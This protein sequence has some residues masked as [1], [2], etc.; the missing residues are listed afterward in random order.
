MKIK[1]LLS[2]LF[3]LFCAAV[4]HAQWDV[5]RE[6]ERMMSF[7]SRP[8]FR[9]EFANTDA[10][11][12]ESV[13]KDFAKKNFSAKLKKSKGEWTATKLRSAFM[14]DEPYAIYSTIE[15][16]GDKA[17]LNVWVDAGTYFLN[18]RDNR[19]RAE[20][21]A[22]SLQQCY[23]DI[24]RASITKDLKAEEDKLK[25]LEGRQKKLQREN[26]AL[27]KDIE[28]WKSKIQK[29]EQDIVNNEQS[30]ESNIVDQEA[31]R[32]QVEEVRRRLE[33]VENEGGN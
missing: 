24:R 21:M 29:A 26:E 11:V 19:G 31:Q 6:T 14:G 9:M 23:F 27:R 18:R 30:Q 10:G 7:G 2:L 15:K 3:T 25:E 28:N 13:W 33:N 16:D 5:V 20:E 32:R 17:S 4:A 12:I 8:C 22:R 1:S